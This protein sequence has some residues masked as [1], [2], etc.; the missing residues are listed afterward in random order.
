MNAP[1]LKLP[2]NDDQPQRSFERAYDKWRHHVA[3]DHLVSLLERKTNADDS[4][5]ALL[6]SAFIAGW[7]AGGNRAME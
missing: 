4:I 3:I 7:D 6:E 2:A 1:A 5:D